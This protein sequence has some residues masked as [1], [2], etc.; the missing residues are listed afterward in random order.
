MGKPCHIFS[1][2]SLIL[3]SRNRRWAL[4]STDILAAASSI[5]EA[6]TGWPAPSR[7]QTSVPSKI[8]AAIA[9][10]S[11]AEIGDFVMSFQ[12]S[13]LGRIDGAK[14]AASLA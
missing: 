7:I 12:D 4:S 6:L 1:T 2:L 11:S 5:T 10:L 13:I 9:L 8:G 14:S 3:S